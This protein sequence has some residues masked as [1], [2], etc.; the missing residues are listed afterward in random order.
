MGEKVYKKLNYRWQ[1]ARRTYTNAM[2]WLTSSNTPLSRVLVY[3]TKFGCSRCNR[4]HI[5]S[6]EPVKLGSARATPPWDSGRGW[7]P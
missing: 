6:G 1:T 7:P 2:A 5:S 4:I 3:H